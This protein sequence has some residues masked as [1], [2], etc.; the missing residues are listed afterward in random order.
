M[1]EMRQYKKERERK[2]KDILAGCIS[3]SESE[4]LE[5]DSEDDASSSEVHDSSP[6]EGSLS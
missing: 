6:S 5:S 2:E 1:V 4:E 3:S